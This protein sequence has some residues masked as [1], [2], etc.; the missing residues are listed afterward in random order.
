MGLT[1]SSIF[2]FLFFKKG[3]AEPPTLGHNPLGLRGTLPIKW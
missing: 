3:V 2:Y 1:I